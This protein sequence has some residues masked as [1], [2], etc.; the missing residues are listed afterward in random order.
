VNEHFGELE[1]QYYSIVVVGPSGV[2]KS[3]L[4][5]QLMIEYPDSFGFCISHTTRGP[6]SGEVDGTHYYFISREQMERKIANDDFIEHAEVHG[7]IYGTSFETV[8]NVTRHKNCI[9]DVDVQGALSIKRVNLK[10]SFF[11]FV[12]PPSLEDLEKRLRGRGTEAEEKILIRLAN[13][14]KEMAHMNNKNLFN[15][16]IVNEDLESCYQEFKATILG[17]FK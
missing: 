9:L 8:Q 4:I 2:G 1:S 17:L 6:R 7:N 12:A 11:L 15:K 10:P 14:K 13:A 16:V 3:T 5:Q